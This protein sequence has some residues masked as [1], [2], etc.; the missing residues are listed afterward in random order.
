MKFLLPLVQDDAKHWVYN[1][2]DGYIVFVIYLS[3]WS[4][5]FI[6][7]YIPDLEDHEIVLQSYST[8]TEAL[9]ALNDFIKSIGYKV[10]SEHHKSL[11]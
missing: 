6:D 5:Y 4:T 2:I 3:W 1:H 10:I 8:F 9:N 11:I 7:I